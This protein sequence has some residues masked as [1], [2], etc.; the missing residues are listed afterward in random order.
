MVD[1]IEKDE[2]SLRKMLARDESR[3]G[4]LLFSPLRCLSAVATS[5]LVLLGAGL[6]GCASAPE[7]AE[8][9]PMAT[10]EKVRAPRIAPF[11][12]AH[13]D[14]IVPAGWYPFV[15]RR[16]KGMTR[17]VTAED[18]GRTVLRAHAQASSTALICPVDIDPSSYPWLDWEWK[19]G[20]IDDRANV[21][22][23]DRD[24]SPARLMVSFD[25]DMSRLGLGDLLFFEQ[26]E[27]FT[28]KRLAYA[29][30]MYVW[31]P[32]L[33]VGTVVNYSRSSRVRYL[34]VES[35]HQRLGQWVSYRRNLA[36]DYRKVFGEEPGRLLSVAVMTDTDDL[37]M[38]TDVL[39]GDV[40]LSER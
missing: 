38:T 9:V 10:L 13:A 17:Y 26:V 3:A 19:V 23:G 2:T 6:A 1:M 16:D 27:L 28:G 24:D 14:G 37:K 31:D 25:G 33:P 4:W 34:V 21:A 8:E 32:V 11:S 15:M 12:A 36:E 5:C 7:L 30:L 22:E 39:Y 35:G 40:S 20:A 29:T 18:G